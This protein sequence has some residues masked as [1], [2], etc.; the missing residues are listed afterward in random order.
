MPLLTASGLCKE[1]AGE[2]LFD[3]VSFA[4]DRGDRIALS[5]PNGAGK[6]TLLRVLA[7]ESHASRGELSVAKGS[8]LVL[9]GQ[10]PPA[11]S[12]E[13]LDDYVLGTA[14][15]LIEIER[16]LASL[17]RSMSTGDTRPST[18]SEYSRLQST[19]EYRGGYAWRERPRATLRGLGFATEDLPRSLSTFSGAE[20]TRAS[21]ARALSVRAD[22]LLLD[23][24]T[25]HLDLESLEWLELELR[26]LDAGIVIVAHDRWL[27]EAS[28]TAVLELERGRGTYFPGPWHAWRKEKAARESASS[29]AAEQRAEQLERLERFV[30]RF[31]YGTRAR[32]AQAK[33]KQIERLKRAGPT[34]VSRSRRTLDFDFP[35]PARSARVV[36][37]ADA[38]S[39]RVG[40]RPLMTDASLVLER[41]E[42]VALVGPNGSG[43][44]TLLETLV[45]RRTADGGEL[46]RGYGVEIGYFSQHD[47][48]L[49]EVGT[50]LDA[51]SQATGLSRG[52]AHGLLGHFLFS[53]E[54]QEK[55]MATLSGG[56]RRRL[57]LACVV[58][59]GA[60]VL[61][62]DE[63]TNHLDLESREALEAALERFPGAVLIASHDRALL[64][65]LADRI[66]AIEGG[67]LRSFQ[68]GWAELARRW[69]A[70][71]ELP[72]PPKPK[73][74][75]RPAQRPRCQPPDRAE[76]LR[77][78]EE[79]IAAA[80]SAL[81]E[82]EVR[83][84]EEWSSVA[85]Q[86]E[87]TDAREKLASLMATWEK[88]AEQDDTA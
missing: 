52:Q 37:Q 22:V 83:L 1:I 62:L 53:G 66:V 57:A 5:G 17:E 20:L 7:G 85:L 88:L 40:N 58:A 82:V 15:D 76:E 38:I 26:S 54:E 87:H 73:A 18:L 86:A 25:N 11:A 3:G 19:L 31:R 47:V 2:P 12:A 72:V 78:L 13:S 34:S 45:G 9:H 46:R 33:L 44:T 56:E 63:P 60:N 69:Q 75:P 23:E 48:E 70:E 79:Q 65:A 41:G 27:L 8:R 55:S 43:K 32:Q 67:S 6:T 28:T 10:R 80:E 50:A 39:L 14:F 74:P 77:Q 16:R 24:P 29:R 81:V 35:T 36:L 71:R 49:G 30:A 68:G 64:D 51:A 4:I 42:H 21:L 59:S 61:V 84:A